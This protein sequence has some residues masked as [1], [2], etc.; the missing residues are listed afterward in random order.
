MCRIATAR[1]DSDVLTCTLV[2]MHFP[3]LTRTRLLTMISFFVSLNWVGQSLLKL[4]PQRDMESS[5]EL[6]K[7]TGHGS[8]LV[9]GAAI[10]K[11]SAHFCPGLRG[12][13]ICHDSTL[14]GVRLTKERLTTPIPRR[15]PAFVLKR[16]RNHQSQRGGH[17]LSGQIRTNEKQMPFLNSCN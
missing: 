3:C 13:S 11:Q 5:P 15:I 16:I 9:K 17:L 8:L 4:K 14:S 7:S 6:S 10:L 1:A 2:Y 12:I